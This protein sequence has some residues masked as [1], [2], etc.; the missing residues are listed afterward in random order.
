MAPSVPA[1]IPSSSKHVRFDPATPGLRAQKRRVVL[2]VEADARRDHHGGRERDD[3]KREQK[4]GDQLT[5]RAPRS[6]LSREEVH[7][8]EK[9]ES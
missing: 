3:Q 8:G 4:D 9:G 1:A 7:G 2:H 6:L 5:A